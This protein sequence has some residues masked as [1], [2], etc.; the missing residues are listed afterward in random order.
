[1]PRSG[2][3][4]RAR[5]SRAAGTPRSRRRDRDRDR[6][7]TNSPDRSAR[8][9]RRRARARRRS[10]V[11]LTTMLPNSSGSDSR[12][13]VR[14]ATWNASWLGTGGWF[15]TPDA[16]CTFW[17][18]SAWVTSSAVRLS[19]CSLSGIEPDLHRVVAR[20]EHGDR[21][22][23]IDAGQHVLDLDVGVVGDEERIARLVRRDRDSPPSGCRANS[24]PPSR[25][26]AAPAAA[27]A[28]SRWRR[29]SAPAPARCRD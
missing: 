9:A 16:T 20:A 6:S 5:S 23:A 27:A 10:A 18:C 4:S 17:P 15:S 21:A 24:W 3:R 26:S 1:M 13:S 25:R 14:T 28:A 11:C 12:P 2:R 7:W 8:R 29:G 19:D 22:D